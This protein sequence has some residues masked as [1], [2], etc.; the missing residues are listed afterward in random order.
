MSKTRNTCASSSRV[1]TYYCNCKHQNRTGYSL[2]IQAQ[3][4]R[5][6]GRGRGSR[7]VWQG[8]VRLPALTH[9][10]TLSASQT[11]MRSRDMTS[12]YTP[13]SCWIYLLKVRRLAACCTFTNYSLRPIEFVVGKP[14]P[15]HNP[16]SRATNS[17]G[18]RDYHSAKHVCMG[19]GSIPIY[20]LTGSIT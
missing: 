6:R 7:G 8:K 19:H 2:L 12:Q 18:R 20:H 15:P 14:C 1:A 11:S 5:G 17:M 10:K 3:R 9:A 13:N 16:A 4:G